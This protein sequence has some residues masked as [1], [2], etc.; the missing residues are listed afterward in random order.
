VGQISLRKQPA[1][2][3]RSKPH[4]LRDLAADGIG[5]NLARIIGGAGFALLGAPFQAK[6]RE[7]AELDDPGDDISGYYELVI[8]NASLVHV[9][10]CQ[11]LSSCL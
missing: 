11:G 3:G 7:I 5:E 1:G 4:D 10:P 8:E 9:F 6:K 2:N